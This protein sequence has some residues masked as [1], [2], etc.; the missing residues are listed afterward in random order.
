MIDRFELFTNTI[1]EIS[2]Y[3][4]RIATVEMEKY[5]LKGLYA[6]Y[7]VT[8]YRNPDGITATQLCEISNKDKAEISRAVSMLEK[9]GLIIREKVTSNSYRALLK[10]TGEGVSLAEVLCGRVNVIV[11]GA[12]NGVSREE[13]ETF[14][15]VFGT[16]TGN[17]KAISREGTVK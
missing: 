15:R 7:I 4:N 1:S 9:K 6:L 11:E 3:W 12:S 13:L 17:L 5:G 2:H 14:Y 8:L 10:L 16:I